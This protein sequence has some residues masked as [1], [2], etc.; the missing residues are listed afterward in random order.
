MDSTIHG[1][2]RVFKTILNDWKDE[3]FV[4]VL[5]HGKINLYRY[6]TSGNDFYKEDAFNYRY[7]IQQ[8]G[9]LL[10]G[11]PRSY[12]SILRQIFKPKSN[13]WVHAIA[14]EDVPQFIALYND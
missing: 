5:T 1:A 10:R 7:Y 4:E 14:Y 9:K 13:S 3:V 12:K 8:E 2:T 6:Y 11:S